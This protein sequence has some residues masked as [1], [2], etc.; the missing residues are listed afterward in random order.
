LRCFSVVAADAAAAA[1]A[2]EKGRHSL[3]ELIS[4]YQIVTQVGFSSVLLN[5]WKRNVDTAGSE[6]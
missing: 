5:Q 2:A 4:G 6:V 3:F 1:A